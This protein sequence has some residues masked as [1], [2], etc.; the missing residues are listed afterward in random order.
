MPSLTFSFNESSIN[1]LIEIITPILLD[2]N[3]NV[4]DT[5]LK[6]ASLKSFD[7]DNYYK[8]DINED[9][10]TINNLNFADRN[11]NYWEVTFGALI[12]IDD[13]KWKSVDNYFKKNAENG[14]IKV[15]F[16]LEIDGDIF[17]IDEH[18]EIE[19]EGQTKLFID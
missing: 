4:K 8:Y 17:E 12:I 2:E 14:L 1:T 16:N 9:E 5:K 15:G 6:I 10:Y 11:N 19:T 7:D 3:L 13:K 18:F